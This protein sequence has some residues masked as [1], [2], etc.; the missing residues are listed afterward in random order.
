MNNNAANMSSLSLVL[1]FA[2][3][4]IGLAINYKEELGLGKD[5]ASSHVVEIKQSQF[6]FC[7]MLLPLKHQ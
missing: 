1:S 4:M 7:N 6:Y 3:V 2:L 5:N